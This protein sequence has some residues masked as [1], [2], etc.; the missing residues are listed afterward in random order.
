VGARPQ[1]QAE[2][3]AP[4]NELERDEDADGT[5]RRYANEA[6]AGPYARLFGRIGL[7]VMIE[8]PG[9]DAVLGWRVEQERKLRARIAGI[10]GR[11]A[12]SDAEVARFVAHYERLTRHILAEMPARADI[13]VRLDAEREAELVRPGLREAGGGQ[14]RPAAV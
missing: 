3:I 10:E 1:P 2:L 7:L 13:L 8:V 4:V 14:A 6:L 11:R 12:M 9:F 5:W